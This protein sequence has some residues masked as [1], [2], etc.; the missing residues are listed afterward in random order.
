MN[1]LI[2]IKGTEYPV[3]FIRLR[4]QD[5]RF[6]NRSTVTIVTDLDYADVVALFSEPGAWSAIKRIEGSADK[7]TDCT[8]YEK[9]LS[10]RDD[11]S[12]TLEVVVGKP[13]DAEILTELVDVLDETAMTDDVIGVLE[14]YGYSQ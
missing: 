7:V 5:F 13:T 10:I 12:G 3:S 1:N 14:K 9:L 2:N 11:R 8:A 4:E 6:G